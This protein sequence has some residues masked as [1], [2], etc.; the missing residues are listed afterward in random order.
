MHLHKED[1]SFLKDLLQTLAHQ[2]Y[3]GFLAT[4]I[5]ELRLLKQTHY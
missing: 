4:N 1:L 2:C 3:E 5:N